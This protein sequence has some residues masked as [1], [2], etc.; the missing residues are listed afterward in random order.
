MAAVQVHTQEMGS[1]GDHNGGGN[2]NHN[3]NHNGGGNGKTAIPG[4]ILVFLTGQDEIEAMERL[5]TDR[6]AVDHS[7]DYFIDHCV[8]LYY[9]D[10]DVDYRQCSS[11]LTLRLTMLAKE[12]AHAHT[13][14]DTSN[15]APPLL[16]FRVVPIYAALPQHKQMAVFEPTPAGTRKVRWW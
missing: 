8:D 1:S 13:N 7:V 2:N 11:L 10:H 6:Y 5:L 9:F 15:T 16:D 4:D 12:H 14:H 3:G